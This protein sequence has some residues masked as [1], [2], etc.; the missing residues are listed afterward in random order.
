MAR[1]ARR[2]R[3]TT[4]YLAA[5]RRFIR[6]AGRRVADAD[7]IELGLLLDLRHDLDAAISEAVEG[8]RARGMSWA[9][10]GSAMGTTRQ[11]AYARFG[12]KSYG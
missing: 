9:Y 12:G 8:Q 10:I 1:R 2:E 11:A 3:E 6:A 7:E 4:E 5:A